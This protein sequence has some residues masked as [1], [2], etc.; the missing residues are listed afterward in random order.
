[1]D[2]GFTVGDEVTHFYDPLLAKLIVHAENRETAIQRMQAALKDFIVHGVVT[3]ID[4]L[5]AVLSH[6]DFQNGEVTTRW[7]ETKFNWSPSAEPSFESLIAA[8][9]YEIAVPSSKAQ[10]PG[11]NDIDPYSP[12]KNPRG[13]RIGG[14][15]G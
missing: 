10:V 11:S 12:W 4:F 13:F 2:S 9:L 5:Q 6:P 14:N 7:V 8:S 15:N 3:N 1:M